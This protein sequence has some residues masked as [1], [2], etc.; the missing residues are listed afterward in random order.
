MA[1]LRL[2]TP[3]SAKDVTRMAAGD[4]L[5]SRGSMNEIRE[6]AGYLF[7]LENNH[8]RQF[9]GVNRICSGGTN[10]T[11]LPLGPIVKV[12]GQV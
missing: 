12:K 9:C 8:S 5:D 10:V 4:I 2:P 7:I 3:I 1:S 6:D 11:K